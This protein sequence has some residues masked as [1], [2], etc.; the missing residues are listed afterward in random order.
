MSSEPVYLRLDVAIIGHTHSFVAPSLLVLSQ[1]SRVPCHRAAV[2]SRETG[3]GPRYAYIAEV[4]QLVAGTTVPALN[5]DI[6]NKSIPLGHPGS[7]SD[8]QYRRM[9]VRVH[10]RMRVA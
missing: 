5:S 10:A 6:D 4:Q 7:S 3:H 8:R 1:M 9:G 2:L